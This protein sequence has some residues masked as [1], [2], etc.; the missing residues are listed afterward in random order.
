MS[1]LCFLE[2][3]GENPKGEDAFTVSLSMSPADPPPALGSLGHPP[4]QAGEG[5]DSHPREEPLGTYRVQLHADFGLEQAAATVPYLARL[6]ISHLYSS[7]VLQAVPGS[8]HGYDVVDH[9]RVGHEIGGSA[10]HDLLAEELRAHGLGRLLDIVPNHMAITGEENRWWWDVL[11]NG[12]AS[13]YAAYFDVD[14]DP[15]ESRLR[16]T[17]LLPVLGDHYGRV[18]EAGE[19]RLRWEAGTFGI[20]Y[21]EQVLPVA[22]R[23]LQGLLGS[24]AARCGSDELAFLGE[25]LGD[26]PLPT[27]T[28]RRSVQRRHRDKGVLLSRLSALAGEDPTVSRAIQEEVEELNADPE[29]LDALLEQ[30]NYRLAFWR[31]SGRDLGYRRFFDI[32][33]LVGLR[34]EH[35]PVFWET[36]EMVLRWLA[37]GVVDGLRIDHPD[38]LRQPQDYFERLREAAPEAWLVAEKIL[39]GEEPLPVDWPID[40]TTG[41]D[42]L[43]QVGGLFVD[44]EGEEPLTELYGTFTGEP[45]D[46]E[47]VSRDQRLWVMD[48]MLGSDL[49]RLTSL[50][51]DVCERHRRYRDF[52]RHQLHEALREAIA[53]F[54]VYRT[55]I[56][57]EAA[58]VSPEDRRQ[59]ISAIEV[60]KAH[61]P[62]LDP[63]LFDFL[64]D[65]LL[66]RARGDLESEL[67]MRFQQLTP[68]VMA[69]G[70]EDTAFYRFN[71][72]VALNEVG[73]NPGGFGT[74]LDEFHAARARTLERWP[75]TML[76]TST[77][78]TKR[79]EDVRSRLFLLSE[80]PRRWGEAVRRW[81]AL[82]EPYRTDDLPDR[83]AEYLL[84][85]T[86]VGA[87]PLEVDRATAYMEKAAR[88]AKAHTSW[89][90]PD[91]LYEKALRSLVE[92][93]LGD[94]H[95][96]EELE[97]FVAP[98]LEPGWVTSLAQVLIKMTAPGVPDIYQGTELW[99]F[100]LV[101]PDNRRPVDY[102]LRQR[103]LADIG[104]SRSPEAIWARAAEG[105]PKLWVISR[106]LELRR[107]RPELFGE[108]GGYRPLA[109]RG[110]RASHVV[111]FSRGQGAAVVVPRLVLGLGGDWRGTVVELPAGRW[112]DLLSDREVE[113]GEVEVAALLSRFP[114]ALLERAS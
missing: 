49:N 65:L 28:D 96:V 33:S 97:A 68:P 45:T 46:W 64:R 99:S 36:H 50:F 53:G 61:R 4:P 62:D 93:V 12:P 26:L 59:V 13:R 92:G 57:A 2:A 102:G 1:E 71:R 81:S 10:G 5:E 72:L 16:N 35:P 56:R 31:A 55:Y 105:L 103:L 108:Q 7:P 66:L 24:A 44:P 76:T 101:D 6:G 17:V 109:S 47:E 18:L 14:W 30:Q 34:V 8:T 90:D 98:L 75:R 77:H 83:N 74:S 87:W 85:Q 39:E 25:A 37:E 106:S 3:L 54:S 80:M 27:M 52:T 112:S 110:E 23:S 95:F 63:D 86:L 94:R 60:A 40:G 32:N 89:T 19:L 21:H 114:V 29:A 41:Y 100:T 48:H 84:Y 113:G 51:L 79:S 67:V 82:A 15:P 107:R 69:K 73:G 43:N 22:P 38:G 111:A 70:V 11:E 58:Q 91:P 42:F 78:D 20:S 88:E 9:S 104:A